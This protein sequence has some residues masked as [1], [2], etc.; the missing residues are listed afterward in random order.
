MKELWANTRPGFS[1]GALLILTLVLNACS[2]G[3]KNETTGD[4]FASA[5]RTTSLSAGDTDCPGG[6]IL[7]ETGIDENGNGLL[8]DIEV[9]SAEKVCNGNDGRNALVNQSV[10]AAGANCAFG[11]VR[12][13]VGVDNN[14]NGLLDRGE[15]TTTEFICE[16]QNPLSDNAR[17]D[18]ITL[19]FGQLDQ[20]FQSSQL[21]YTASVNYLVSSLQITAFSEDENASLTIAGSATA[22]GTP[23]NPVSLDQGGNRIVITVT[24]QDGVSTRSYTLGIVRQKLQS[25]AQQAYVKAS[26]T[27]SD[28]NF[29]RSVALSGDTLA[30]GA[31]NEGSNG[32]GV[33]GGAQADN[34]ALA[35]GAV[36]VFTRSNGLWSQQA[37]IKAS[38]TDAA[39]R[40]GA[41]IA[42][43]GNTLAVGAFGEDSNGTGVNGDAQGDNT[44]S[45]A[46]SVYV[47]TRSNGVWSQQAYIKASNID[48]D[49]RFGI[50]V[51]LSGNTLAVGASGEDSNGTGVNGGAQADNSAV[52]SG[53]VYVF[54]RSMG[55]WNQQAYIKASNTDAGDRFGF[56]VALSGDTLAVGA[57]SE[58]SNGTGVN[59]GAQAD[60]SALS[61]GAVYVFTHSNGL[62]SQQAYVKASNTDRGDIFGRSVALSGD[63]LAVG[64]NLESSN[65]T[66]VNGNAQA[67]NSALFAGA[68]Y[69]FTRSNDRWSQ[70]AYVKASNTD[71]GD[72][73]GISVALSGDTLAVGAL[74]EGSNGTGING[75]AQGDNTASFAGSVYLYTR[76]NGEWNQK[77][78]VKASNTD[79]DDEFGVNVA[80]SGDTLAVGANFESSN[81][82]GVNGGSQADNSLL[83]SGAVYVLP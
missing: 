68:V 10:E 12:F 13:D 42:L 11:G 9:D 37:Y 77:A 65:G 26:N 15:V 66:G 47:F 8:E 30:V 51:A 19:S 76:S 20:L 27:G 44:A 29:G 18:G 63:M 36:Y 53:A 23:S 81:G 55:V 56:S 59:G 82:T 17:L 78:Y 21:D 57:I 14:A 64:A 4:L 22:S 2:G 46:G 32:T 28:D 67:D 1:I 69:V 50:S 60:N 75:G 34:S 25:F 74:G 48:A 33:N 40:F 16:T 71:A 72:Q 80:L 52:D 79:A 73:F 45:F 39:D 62:W 24:A 54:T 7:V 5:A 61:S 58:S 38:N 41:S 3:S 35:S 6:G 31:I 43:S 83:S 70:H 49:D